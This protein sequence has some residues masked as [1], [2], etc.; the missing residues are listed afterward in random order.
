MRL[1]LNYK[2]L[3]LR[4]WDLLLLLLF[5]DFETDN[6]FS[7]NYTIQF[8]TISTQYCGKFCILFRT[9]KIQLSFTKIRELTL[10]TQHSPPV[11]HNWYFPHPWHY[12]FHLR[13]EREIIYRNSKINTTSDLQSINIQ[14]MISC[15][16]KKKTFC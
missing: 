13:K 6:N 5:W 14:I 15:F 8:Q 12:F 10:A 3:D 11:K 1:K 4:L 16:L 9:K 2:D 7:I